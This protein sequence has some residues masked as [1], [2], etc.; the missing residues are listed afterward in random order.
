[1]G[2]DWD[3]MRSDGDL[4]GFHGHFFWEYD[5]SHVEILV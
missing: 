5:I 2:L 1:M 4:R 3:F